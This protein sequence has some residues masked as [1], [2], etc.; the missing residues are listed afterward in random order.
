MPKYAEKRRHYKYTSMQARTQLSVMDRNYSVGREHAT[1]LDGKTIKR[2]F[3]DT[4]SE[5]FVSSNFSLIKTH[6]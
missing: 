1:A 4:D 2:N 5:S 3:G 6:G